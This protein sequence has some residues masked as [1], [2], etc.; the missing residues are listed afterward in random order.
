M[1]VIASIWIFGVSSIISPYYSARA[2]TY[3]YCYNDQYNDAYCFT[4]KAE[5]ERQAQLA[6]L[7][8]SDCGKVPVKNKYTFTVDGQ[9]FSFED[10]AECEQHAQQYGLE[11]T[12]V[13]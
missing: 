1:A 2:Y 3:T 13:Q 6:G 7:D 12:R 11:C 9:T 8:K 5:C 10:K 4:G